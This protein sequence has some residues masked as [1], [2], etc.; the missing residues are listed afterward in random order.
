[1]VGTNP[2]AVA[3]CFKRAHFLEDADVA[4]IVGEER[5]RR[6]HQHAKH[7]ARR[8]TL[9]GSSYHASIVANMRGR[10]WRFY[11]RGRRSKHGKMCTGRA[12]WRTHPAYLHLP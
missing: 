12:P 5:G 4:A 3:A 1:M 6:D 11:S 9:I 8:P 7:G 2:H 10:A